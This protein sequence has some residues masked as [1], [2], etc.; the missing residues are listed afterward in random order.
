M[1]EDIGT[2]KAFYS[3]INPTSTQ[4]I[5]NPFFMRVA[6]VIGT[7]GEIFFA[8]HVLWYCIIITY[9]MS[10]EDD[11]QRIRGSQQER[12]FNNDN[13]RAS[14]DVTIRTDNVY[15]SVEEFSLDLFL[16]SPQ[17]GF[18][19]TPNVYTVTILDAIIGE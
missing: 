12:F 14:A 9:Y 4:T 19:V 16:A 8:L 6:T 1:S 17:T 10:D 2:F 13:R 3:V 15:E 7:A 18:F 5:A 11:Y